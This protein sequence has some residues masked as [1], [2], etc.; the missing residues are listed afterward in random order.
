MSNGSTTS[1]SGTPVNLVVNNPSP[2]IA[3]VSPS[4]ELVNSSSPVI[5]VN[6]T[7]FVSTTVIDING[8]ARSTTYT[9]ATQVS[10][11]LTTA[12][13]STAGALST[14]AVNPAPGGGTSTAVSVAVNNPSIGAIQLNPGLLIVGTTTPTTITVTGNT[15]VPGAVIQVNGTARATTY[16]NATTVTFVATVADQ[17]TQAMLYV[18]ATNPSPGGGTSPISDLNVSPPTATPVISSVS[19][20]AFYAGSAATTISITGTGLTSN[21]IVD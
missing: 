12:D 10:A 3:S 18:T 16:V 11:T 15:F 5:T 4:I 20:N 7:G 19:P 14:T 1:S 9:S 2:T 21:S 6:G 13:L 17:A 8:S